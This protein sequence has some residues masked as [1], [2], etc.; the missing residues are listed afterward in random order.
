MLKQGVK[1]INAEFIRTREP[2]ANSFPGLFLSLT[3]M[4]KS[5]KTLET[6]LDLTPS[7]KTS[8]NARVEG[9]V[10]NVDYLKN[11]RRNF[12][13]KEKT[14]AAHTRFVIWTV[15]F[16][17][18]RT[19]DAVADLCLKVKKNKKRLSPCSLNS[20]CCFFMFWFKGWSFKTQFKIEFWAPVNGCRLVLE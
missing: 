3:L 20:V 13:Q 14:S 12:I 2:Y 6:S 18:V 8:V 5:K 9:L 19:S 15:I 1:T 16:L 17:F 4:L 10:S 7:F 11:W